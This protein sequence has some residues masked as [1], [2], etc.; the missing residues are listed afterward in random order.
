MNNIFV[1]GPEVTGE[2]QIGY[3][4]YIDELS[5]VLSTVGN[6]VSI[7][8]LKKIGKT[9]IAK[10]VLKRIK[11]DNTIVISIDLAKYKTLE[12]FHNAILADFKVKL[13][14]IDAAEEWM[15]SKKFTRYMDMIS[16]AAP[17]S[18]EFDTYL[19]GLLTATIKQGFRIIL[20]IDEFDAASDL[21]KHT[22]DYEYL[23]DLATDGEA[24]V[25]LL[26]VSRRQLYMIEK[27]NFNNSTFHGIMQTYPIDGFN[28]D[29]MDLF[30][31]VLRD[32]YSIELND[33]TIE[34]MMYYSGKSPYLMSM[35]AYDIVE[36]SFNSGSF[37][38]NMIYKRRAIDIENYF[39]SIFACLNND[40]VEVIGALEEVSTIEKLV[41]T[42]IGP[43]IGISEGDISLLES[44]GYLANEGG[45][46]YSISKYFTNALHNFPL[47]VSTWD[48]ILALEKKIKALIRKQIKSNLSVEFIDYDVFANIFK[49]VGYSSLNVYDGFIEQVWT[50]YGKRED[51]LD[52]CSL[53][54][55]VS[56]VEY[57][58]EQWFS[59]FFNHDEWFVW[60]DKLR[61]CAKARCPMAHGHNECLTAEQ[62]SSVNEYCSM[63]FKLFASNNACLEEETVLKLEENIRK[64]EF[65]KKYYS[66]NY[67]NVSDEL[68]GATV[69]VSVAVQD[70]NRVKC[71]FDLNGKTYKC[72]I[73]NEKL[74]AKFPNDNIS[75]HLGK[76]IEATITSVNANQ[77]SLVVE[78]V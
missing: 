43:R 52:V 45:E 54:V 71:F 74:K 62:I 69:V 22:A 44:M 57:Y 18:I 48:N 4:R 20:Y 23:R 37:D 29:D 31:N 12:D 76:T 7:T 63:I 10:A 15:E 41:G 14:D 33:E 9:S 6:N 16:S 73:K 61:L 56:I 27:K 59:E 30:F 8:G 53:D 5:R 25:T 46:Y 49:T 1:V 40:K 19:K 17:G 24:R 51:L 64:I 39:K 42:I 55:A 60:R 78:L 26:L 65:E 32:K 67:S 34:K 38:I 28:S 47:R 72:Y 58:W 50:D 35:F 68:N 70:S 66:N 21:F 13:M 36:D 11:T 75:Q 77:N 3:H 2:S